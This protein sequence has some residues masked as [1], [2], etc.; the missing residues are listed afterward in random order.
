M[1]FN[2]HS[3]R[4]PVRLVGEK[5]SSFDLA[6]GRLVLLSG[7]FVLI[8]M[9][10][11]ARA[12][13]LTVIQS[14]VR[15]DEKAGNEK[16]V[17]DKPALSEHVTRGD[18][19]D[20]NG[21]LLATTLKTP[22]LYVDPKHV[23]DQALASKNLALL[24]PD[25]KEKE[26]LHKMQSQKRF[27]LLRRDLNPQEQLDVLRLGEPG[28]GFKYE[29]RRVYPQG[30]LMAHMVGYTNIDNQGLAGIERSYQDVLQTGQPL[31]L[32]LDVR[33]QH[34]LRREIKRAMQEFS[35][36]GGAGL[37]MD[38]TNGQILAGVSMPDFDPQA[39]GETDPDKIFNRLTLGAYELGSVFKIFSTAAFLETHDVPMS[40]SFDASEP[41][42][43]GGFVINDFHAENRVLT[44]PEVFMHSSNIGSA[45][46]GLAVG[47]EKLKSF[48]QDLGLTTPM[49]FDISEMGRPSVPSPWRELTTITSAYGHGIT[50]TPLQM[51]SAVGT[52][53][54][55]GTRVT[56]SLVMKTVD[57][58]SVAQTPDG[59]RILSEK[60]SHRLRQLMRLVVADGTGSKADVPGY[61]VGGKTGTAEKIK[62][63]GYD[64]NKLISSF[65][66][67]FPSEAPRYVVFIMIDEPK[68][69]KESFG[70]ATAGWVA[71]PAVARVVAS[72]T[73][74]LG[75]PPEDTAPEKDIASSLR[76]FVA[77]KKHD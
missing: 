42:R 70:Y 44:I 15:S 39:V 61:N 37:I 18:I 36:I 58:S 20:R 68:G 60:T 6:R 53:V 38:V 35:A 74:I 55:G 34:A 32:T 52:V 71:A 21:T 63:G 69:T 3:R 1:I 2:P 51:A 67:M 23:S 73:S 17:S 66:G 9:L 27:V 75:I 24:F 77:V 29:E 49:K 43:S 45:M 8:Y 26:V 16:V 7:I 25:L 13:D 30:S 41:I 5:S 46:M 31:E 14:S 56:P 12:V 28:L 72:M 48:Y 65:V 47:G 62:V 57:E 59:V 10:L 11:A 64:K 33:L 76:Q 4:N 40:T 19:F 54:N 50:T 22:T